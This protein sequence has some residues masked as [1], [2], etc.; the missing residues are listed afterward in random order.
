[1]MSI[2]GNGFRATIGGSETPG[3]WMLGGAER[4]LER[5]APGVLFADLRACNDY[6]DALTAAA[7]VTVPATVIL[8]SRDVM[9]PA[10]GGKAVAAAI[11]SCRLTVLE[12]AG[13]MLMTERPDEVLAAL[14]A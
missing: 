11:A 13:H 5:A 12:G 3:L 8:G 10:K 6:G 1:M 2:W 4:L 9:T 7:S 14:K